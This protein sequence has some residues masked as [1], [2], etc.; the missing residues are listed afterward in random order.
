MHTSTHLHS[1][2]I[3]AFSPPRTAA[4]PKVIP[5]YATSISRIVPTRLA[6]HDALPLKPRFHPY[7]GQHGV[8]RLVRPTADGDDVE[9]PTEGPTHKQYAGPSREAH[10]I[11]ISPPRGN[12][13]VA[14]FH[15]ST[16]TAKKN[17]KITKDAI[18]THLVV[19]RCL[20]EQEPTARDKAREHIESRIPAFKLHEDH[21]GAD[22][23]LREQLKTIKDTRVKAEKRKERRQLEE[24]DAPGGFG[25][26]VRRIDIRPRE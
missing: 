17:R 21:W 16:Q 18:E 15:W 13:N 1:E 22:V 5:L 7:A 10:P 19:G 4:R 6:I 3:S 25:D 20:S 24:I 14:I 11:L 8:D 2:I 23:L 12:L 26:N 9:T